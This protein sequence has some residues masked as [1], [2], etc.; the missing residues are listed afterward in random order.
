MNMYL[1]EHIVTNITHIMY[2]NSWCTATCLEWLLVCQRITP[3]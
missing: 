3:R 1:S 2:Y